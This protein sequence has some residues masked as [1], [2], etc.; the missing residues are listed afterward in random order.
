MGDPFVKTLCE[1]NVSC[2]LLELSTL[3]VPQVMTHCQINLS[4]ADSTLHLIIKAPS[5]AFLF[6]YGQPTYCD[7]RH[8]QSADPPLE[9]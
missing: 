8:I 9:P 4:E 7:G 6:R 3:K 5:S 1:Q 2:Q